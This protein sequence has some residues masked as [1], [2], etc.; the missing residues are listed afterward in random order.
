MKGR[1]VGGTLD[2]VDDDAAFVA[3]T[4]SISIPNSFWSA[5]IKKEAL[6]LLDFIRWTTPEGEDGS[7]SR[8]LVAGYGF[9]GI[10][11][12]QVFFSTPHRSDEKRGWEEVLLDMIRASK[13]T[14]PGKLSQIFSALVSTVSHLSHLF[15]RFSAKYPIANF[16]EGQGISAD[17]PVIGKL[18][19]F[20][21]NFEDVV[22]ESESKRRLFSWIAVTPLSGRMQASTPY[23]LLIHLEF[24]IVIYDY[25]KWP[26]NIRLWWFE[27]LQQRLLLHE[28][29]F[30]FVTSSYGPVTNLV[31]SK[32]HLLDMH[33]KD[34]KYRKRFIR[35]K[36]DSLLDHG[37]GSVLLG[38]GPV[39]D[40]KSRV[41]LK[42]M[43]FE[44]SLK[45][46]SDYLSLLFQSFPLT[47]ADAI[48]NR[49]EPSPETECDFYKQ[50]ILALAMKHPDVL[51]WISSTLS[52][53]MWAVRPL[54]LEELAVAN[55]IN[56]DADDRIDDPGNPDDDNQSNFL[57]DPD[58]G[59]EINNPKYSGDNNQSDF[60]G[61]VSMDMASDL[62]KHM[63]GIV[64]VA[65]NQPR[66][67]S[68]VAKKNL[69]TEL[70]RNIAGSIL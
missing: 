45:T 13:T 54:C 53:I 59:D 2:V 31:T 8:I 7:R 20:D 34:T 68:V 27:E 32:T 17:H 14:F 10:V 39:T 4:A 46:V 23:L 51:F 12:K 44:G 18:G 30:T 65:N 41:V 70:N 5:S 61:R 69:T 15:Y 47:T 58:E 16:I 67:D 22:P 63:S 60:L 57:Q 19:I 42:A 9:G 36:L 49:I 29:R 48:S 6:D 56:L 21:T 55:A 28:T 43:S 52:W 35:A 40:L 3:T 1:G 50:E 26:K 25:E 11:V 24:L 37:Y 64:T 62:R 33:K 38:H 66:I